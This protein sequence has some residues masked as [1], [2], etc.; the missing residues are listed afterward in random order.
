MDVLT[1]TFPDATLKSLMSQDIVCRQCLIQIVISPSSLTPPIGDF[2]SILGFRHHK[3][4][5]AHSLTLM[6]PSLYGLETFSTLGTH[7]H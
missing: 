4:Y 3:L 5:N 6:I 2:L 7:P 1:S